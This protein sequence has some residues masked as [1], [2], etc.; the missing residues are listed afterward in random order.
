MNT[1]TLL[2][3]FNQAEPAGF[4]S[5]YPDKKWHQPAFAPGFPEY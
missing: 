3:S 4:N 5:K 2:T 1:K